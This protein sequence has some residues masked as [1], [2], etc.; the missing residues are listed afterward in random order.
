MIIKNTIEQLNTRP[1][2]TLIERC[3]SVSPDL[4]IIFF[5]GSGV[6]IPSCLPSA[7][8]MID[9]TIKTIAPQPISGQQDKLIYEQK[10]LSEILP[11]IYYDVIRD[12]VG[13]NAIKAWEVLEFW[14]DNIELKK[15]HLGPNIAHYLIVFLASKGKSPVITTNF[16]TLFE[17]AALRLGIT[18][19]VS[20]PLSKTYKISPKNNTVAIWKVHGSVDNLE[21][22]RT[23]L[24]TITM[25]DTIKLGEI[26]K[27]FE[28]Q[29]AD[30]CFVG[31]SG[32][33][34][35][36][37]PFILSWKTG[38]TYFWLD[39]YFKEWH[40][41]YTDPQKFT[42]IL[43]DSDEWAKPIISQLDVMQ[44]KKALID[45]EKNKAERE[46]AKNE[47]NEI[48][49]SHIINVFENFLREDFETTDLIH[50]FSLRAIGLSKN[51]KVY[52]DRF[53]K[54]KQG[55]QD[56]RSLDLLARAYLLKAST[57]HETSKYIDSEENAKFAKEIAT[58]NQNTYLIDE[59]IIAADEA[60][61]MQHLPKLNYNDKSLIFRLNTWSVFLQLLWHSVY[62]FRKANH[63]TKKQ[64]A[65]EKRK[66][67][68]YIEH[69]IRFFGSLQGLLLVIL[70][71]KFARLILGNIWATIQEQSLRVGFANGVGF[72][73][74][75]AERLGIQ[76]PV[77]SMLSSTPIFDFLEEETGKIIALMDTGNNILKEV[78]NIKDDKRKNIMH[79]EA[80]EK[81]DIGYQKAFEMENYSLCL[82]ILI[83]R[84]K[85]D[86]NFRPK[87]EDVS[88]IFQNIQGEGYRKV[89]S[90]IIK[91]L[92]N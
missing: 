17:E 68:I 13:D 91:W 34:I 39:P 21:S 29:G 80:V 70:P 30:V 1:L 42:A 67:F 85:V 79:Q 55:L 62:F 44:L 54:N 2:Q 27:Q 88:F 75:Y 23:T 60:L 77:S 59:S 74:R 86:I 36:L 49:K 28:R 32:R 14:K 84:R 19:E 10:K 47:Y 37:F 89:E 3:I 65:I 45:D 16:D 56:K 11:E 22:I 52:I 81:F 20:T 12:L 76:S 18:P 53:I 63:F 57:M 6:S 26:Q 87:F 8:A 5:A 58:R 46:K 51:A 66:S 7:Y 50:A 35:D 40:R 83:T 72:S 25:T 61:R 43:G 4:P 9:T 41:I 71:L 73:R 31:Y 90:E 78:Q 82:K 69:L 33:D 64:S 15:F 92:C 48:I 38:S 24:Q